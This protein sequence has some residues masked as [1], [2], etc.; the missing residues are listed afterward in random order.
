MGVMTHN[1][2]KLL[3]DRAYAHPP[4]SPSGENTAC[5]CM[6]NCTLHTVLLAKLDSTGNNNKSTREEGEELEVE[7]QRQE[8]RLDLLVLVVVVV[9]NQRIA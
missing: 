3:V 2:D 9:T 1:F 6:Y 5:S 4:I 7:L 8:R